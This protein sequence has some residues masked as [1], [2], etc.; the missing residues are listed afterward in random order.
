MRCTI[1]SPGSRPCEW[2]AIIRPPGARLRASGAKT[3]DALNSAD[4][5][6]RYGC[7]YDLG[8]ASQPYRA[9]AS[10]AFKASKVLAPLARRLA[11]GQRRIATHPHRRAPGLRIA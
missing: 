8:I 2:I 9:R 4:A 1:S 11:P 7:G 5:R 10:A 3:L 6:A